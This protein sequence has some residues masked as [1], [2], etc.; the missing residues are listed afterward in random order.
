MQYHANSF[1]YDCPYCGALNDRS[2]CDWLDELVDDV[3]YHQVECLHCGK[4]IDVEVTA[5]Y[6]HKAYK[7]EEEE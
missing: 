6:Y 3:V 1:Q 2:S 4:Q 7:I 5:I